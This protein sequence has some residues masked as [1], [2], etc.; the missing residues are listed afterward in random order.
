M[1]SNEIR[2]LHLLSGIARDLVVVQAVPVDGGQH[3]VADHGQGEGL[4]HERHGGVPHYGSGHRGVVR[5]GKGAAADPV[6]GEL[7]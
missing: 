4:D 2:K 7:V 6:H 1:T 5:G 3:V